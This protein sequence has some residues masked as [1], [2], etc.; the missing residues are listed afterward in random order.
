MSCVR[1]EIQILCYVSQAIYLLPS[2]AGSFFWGAQ[3][4]DQES[5]T[6]SLVTFTTY[7]KMIKWIGRISFPWYVKILFVS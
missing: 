1:V 3:N 7:S 6:D 2:V 5:V 4:V